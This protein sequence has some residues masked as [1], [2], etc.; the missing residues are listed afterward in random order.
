MI[1]KLRNIKD[2]SIQS[3][4]EMNSSFTPK[5]TCDSQ[6]IRT[7]NGTRKYML[8]VASADRLD[9]TGSVHIVEVA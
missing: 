4:H 3:H 7:R 6:K 9:L 2:Q 5:L 8:F 1:D